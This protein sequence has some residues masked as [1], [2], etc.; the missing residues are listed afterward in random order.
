MRSGFMKRSRE[1]NTTI[2]Q[3]N[4]QESPMSILTDLASLLD[5]ELDGAA[6]AGTISRSQSVAP[7]GNPS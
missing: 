2:I 3:D 4:Q 1:S 6:W 7:L 5:Y